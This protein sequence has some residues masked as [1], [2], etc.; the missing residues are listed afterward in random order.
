LR[1]KKTR[2]EKQYRGNLPIHCMSAVGLLPRLKAHPNWTGFYVHSSD[3]SVAL[4]CEELEQAQFWVAALERARAEV[5]GSGLG[6]EEVVLSPGAGALSPSGEESPAVTPR[7]AKRP[8]FSLPSFRPRS[9]TLAE[10]V[11]TADHDE[12]FSLVS[13]MMD[14]ITKKKEVEI[15][16]LRGRIRE[17][18]ADLEDSRRQNASLASELDQARADREAIAKQLETRTR[19]HGDL[20][21]EFLKLK[22][23]AARDRAEVETVQ[24][25]LT[26]PFW[27]PKRSPKKSPKKKSK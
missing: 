15:D 27:S 19:L 22:D 8:S 12:Q 20:E 14:D 21:I 9:R 13:G 4:C 1:Y 3:D 7:A 2:E 25:V 5:D 24:T 18:E 10:V 6:L 23:R 17:L 11:T 16:E 26:T